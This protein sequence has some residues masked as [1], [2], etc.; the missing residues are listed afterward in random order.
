M[1][2]KGNADLVPW[3]PQRVL[4]DGRVPC[5]ACDTPTFRSV[6]ERHAA[7][8]HRGLCDAC[9]RVL[10]RATS[11][12]TRYVRAPEHDRRIAA[13]DDFAGDGWYDFSSGRI[14]HVAVG[15]NPNYPR[16]DA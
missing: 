6:A 4:A 1:I 3:L 8:W 10:A 13:G 15:H 2:L 5:E 12:C 9:A 16:E 14:H 11:P 7:V